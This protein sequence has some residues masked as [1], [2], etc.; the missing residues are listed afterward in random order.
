VPDEFCIQH[1]IGAWMEMP[2]WI[3]ADP[4]SIGFSQVSIDRALSHGLTFRP[5]ADTAKATLDWAKT[6]PKDRRWRAGLPAEKEAAVLKAWHERQGDAPATG[7]TT[8][9][10]A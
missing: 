7:A 4:D 6:R 1:G 8:S 5:L 2:L 10:G 3:P 9:R